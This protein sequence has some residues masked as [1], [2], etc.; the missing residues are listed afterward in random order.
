MFP[1]YTKIHIACHCLECSKADNY[2]WTKDLIVVPS[3]DSEDMGV[4]STE[5]GLRSADY[6]QESGDE[7]VNLSHWEWVAWNETRKKIFLEDF[8]ISK[9]V[10]LNEFAF[11]T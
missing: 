7:T 11:S 4:K 6:D 10:T 9:L 3:D 1:L 2:N 8:G 5:F